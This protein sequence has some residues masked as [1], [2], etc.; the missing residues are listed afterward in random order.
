VFGDA[1]LTLIDDPDRRQAIGRQAREYALS[2]SWD[3]IMSR[4]R[5]R[6]EIAIE[7]QPRA[8]TKRVLIRR[9]NDR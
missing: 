1:L 7:Q 6:Y 3:Q 5:E 8:K 2:Q 4:L 9:A